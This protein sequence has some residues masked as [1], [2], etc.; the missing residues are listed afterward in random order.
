MGGK[1]EK[2]WG[3]GGGWVGRVWGW[4]GGKGVGVRMWGWVYGWGKIFWK[5]ST[6]RRGWEAAGPSKKV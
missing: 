6:L 1:G 2:D 4:N 5:G 3:L